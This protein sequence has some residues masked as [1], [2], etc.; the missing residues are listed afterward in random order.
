MFRPPHSVGVG[1]Q[2]PSSPCHL[3]SIYK[4][5]KASCWPMDHVLL[6]AAWALSSAHPTRLIHRG[7]PPRLPLPQN[8]G[9]SREK[10]KCRQLK[11][12]GNP[13]L[14]CWQRHG[15]KHLRD[16]WKLTV[17]SI[18]DVLIKWNITAVHLRLWG[19]HEENVWA[20]DTWSDPSDHT[21]D[22]SSHGQDGLFLLRCGLRSWISDV[23]HQRS[24]SHV[25][26]E[27]AT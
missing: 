26:E 25:N 10:L 27:V 4:V 24:V 9:E 15:G 18:L 13:R 12:T 8:A 14:I 17:V 22:F 16:K 7:W 11:T 6:P 20:S 2:T 1:D 23:G 5:S 19:Y 3:S 21:S